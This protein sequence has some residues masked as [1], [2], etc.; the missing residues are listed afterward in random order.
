MVND[1][2]LFYQM[3]NQRKVFEIA[4]DEFIFPPLWRRLKSTSEYSVPYL[5]P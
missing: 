2:V 3:D 4:F 1:D 5:G